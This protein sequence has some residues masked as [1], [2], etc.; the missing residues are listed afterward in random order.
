[1]KK[2]NPWL[3]AILNLFLPGIGFAY[4]GG[5]VLIVSGIILFISDTAIDS[6]H[7]RHTV[8]MVLTPWYSIWSLLAGVS[9][10]VV[11]FVLTSIRSIGVGAKREG[12]D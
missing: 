10:A 9:L 7:V 6:I 8:G 11:T 5:P 3:A 4:L 12:F 2:K 1:M